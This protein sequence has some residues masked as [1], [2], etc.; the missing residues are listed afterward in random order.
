MKKTIGKY[1]VL[2]SVFGIIW[3]FFE[4]LMRAIDGEMFR[5]HMT[6]NILNMQNGNETY[7]AL[8]G[9]SSLWMFFV[10]GISVTLLG[11]MNEFNFIRTKLNVF[12]QCF[13]GMFIILL[14]EFGAGM[15]FNQL[16]GLQLWSYEG[17]PLNLFGQIC[18]PLAVL[19]FLLTPVAFWLDDVL[20]KVIFNKGEFYSIFSV[21]SNLLKVFKK[22]NIQKTI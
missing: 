6:S 10:G 7:F 19:W 12:W 14:V 2:F 20:R 16:L 5:T 17:V 8:F 13:I 21:Y 9:F 11:L 22:T 4:V 1:A 18:A 15:L 3:V